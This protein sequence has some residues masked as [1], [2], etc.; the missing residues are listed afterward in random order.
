MRIESGSF[1][2]FPVGTLYEYT[3]ARNCCYA[4]AAGAGAGV[5]SAAAGVTGILNE[6]LQPRLTVSVE[7]GRWP[8][9]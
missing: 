9:S 1:R 6:P 8:E 4:A 5:V 2:G 3:F 7:A